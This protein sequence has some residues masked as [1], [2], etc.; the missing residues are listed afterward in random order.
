MSALA[1]A[2]HREI[3]TPE[4][5]P[6]RFA[7]ARAGDR[8]G[9]FIIDCTFIVGASLVLAVAGVLLTAA[10]RGVGLAVG[11][12]AF[13]LL[14]CF[15]F[16]WFECAWHGATPG[17]RLLG[18]RVIDSHGGTLTPEAV[19]ARNLMREIEL[20]LPLV[21]LMAPEQLLPGVPAWMRFLAF[22]WVFACALL[23]LFNRDGLRVGDL[24]AGT[25]V[26]LAPRALLREDLSA[27]RLGG[28][29][30]APLFS[31]EQ[32]DLYGIRELQVLE[33]LLREG[34]TRAEAIEAVAATI[35]KKIGWQGEALDPGEFLRRFYTAQ[36]AR[37]EHRMVLGERRESKR[38]GRLTRKR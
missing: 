37:L 18:L 5:V 16:P 1:G 21:A 11:I 33:S 20:F 8:L 7:V 12:L 3:L 14:R 31:D 28:Q 15:Y 13:F 27:S 4:G 19:F 30:A 38:S 9:A 34:S 32:L 24:V 35:Q 29:E 26:V 10:T 6:L 17:K 22:G 2:H 23:P 36:R 25:L